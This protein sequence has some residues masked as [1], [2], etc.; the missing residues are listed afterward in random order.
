MSP[1]PATPPESGGST[2]TASSEADRRQSRA[3]QDSKTR[4]SAGQRRNRRH[5]AACAGRDIRIWNRERT[6]EEIRAAIDRSLP[7]NTPRASSSRP[8]AARGAT[9]QAGAKI[10][11]TSDFPPILTADEAAALDAKYAKFRALASQPGDRRAAKSPPHSARPA[12]SWARPAETSAQTSAA[13]AR[14]APRPSSAT[15]SS[16]MPMENGYRIYRVELKT[17]A[18]A[19]VSRRATPTPSAEDQRIPRRKLRDAKFL[20]RSLMPRCRL[21]RHGTASTTFSL[22][23]KH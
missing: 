12:T 20:R 1:P 21:G 23:S 18:C 8:Q 2:S 7:A 6:A 16:P 10:A 15:S 19:R 11:K 22:T 4:A 9:P 14:W 3:R 13:S 5:A 17:G